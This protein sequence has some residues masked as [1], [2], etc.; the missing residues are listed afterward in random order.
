[1]TFVGIYLVVDF[2]EKIDNMLGK[3][4]PVAKIIAYFLYK[5]PFIVTQGI[6][7]AILLG[8]LITLGI[9][10]RS[11]ELIAL[12]ASG[13]SRL[14]YV[15][16]II[17]TAVLATLV[18]FVFSESISRTLHYR[19][20]RIWREDVTRKQ[21]PMTFVHENVWYY[22]KGVIYQIRLYDRENKAM[23]RVSLFYVD[24]DFRLTRRIDARRV[25]WKDSAWN[26]QNGFELSFDEAKTSQ[27][28]F[29]ERSLTLSERPEDFSSIEV[30]PEELNWLQLYRYAGKIKQE[31]FNSL[32][33]EVELHLRIASPMTAL[34][35]G[36]L[37]ISIALR[38]RLEGGVASNIVIALAIGLVFLATL[39]IGSGMATAG[40]LPPWVGV[41]TGNI[42]ACAIMA[43]FW[44]T[45][46]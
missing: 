4:L 30:V 14:A 32:P 41:W 46:V 13:I 29:S 25:V 28:Y 43:Y 12:E 9:L 45:N 27:E 35:F 26:A 11:H 7:V 34:I 23:E 37:A 3:S 2:F 8:A 6:P 21:S 19:S 15:R 17:L 31:G 44:T 42:I 1:M 33:H 18:C 40:L 36:L 20:E 38:H 10:K 22:G 5:I 24:K 39:H 16:P